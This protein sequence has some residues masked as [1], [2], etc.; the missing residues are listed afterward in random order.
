MIPLCFSYFSEDEDV[1]YISENKDH[2]DEDEI[3]WV[4]CDVCNSC[5]EDSPCVL[6]K[7]PTNIP[8]SDQRKKM[9]MLP[10]LTNF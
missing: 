10:F 5:L 2:D 4:C 9:V 1:D 8:S 3:E 6:R 7:W